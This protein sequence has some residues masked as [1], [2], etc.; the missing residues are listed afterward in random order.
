MKKIVV[1]GTALL[2]HLI[3]TKYSLKQQVCNKT[4]DLLISGGA[5]RNVAYNL[6]HLGLT[7]DFIAVWGN[8]YNARNIINEL[9]LVG[10]NCYGPTINKTTPIFTNIDSY[11]QNYLISSITDDFYI[12]DLNSLAEDY[13][14][15]VD[16]LISDSDDEPLILSI[17]IANPAIQ[18]I[19]IGRIPSP[20]LRAYCKGIILNRHEFFSSFGNYEYSVFANSLANC[21][22]VVSL[23]K[24]GVCY[25]QDSYSYTLDTVDKIGYPIGCGDAL[26]A[27]IVY[28]LVKGHDLTNAVKFGVNLADMV[29]SHPGNSLKKM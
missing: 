29:F 21:W 6:G 9:L 12:A 5:M 7:S 10:V 22:L 1:I 16:H 14:A 15:D 27:G 23:D 24:N 13:F 26:T 18:Y 17:L 3:S 4:N 11:N 2:D 20:N 19:Q 25:Y 8:D 28:F